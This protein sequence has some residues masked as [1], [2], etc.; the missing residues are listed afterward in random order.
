MAVTEDDNFSNG[1]ARQASRV[2]NVMKN[3]LERKGPLAEVERLLLGKVVRQVHVDVPDDS[4]D[5]GDDLEFDYH[6]P[7]SDISCMQDKVDSLE[8]II[9]PGSYLSVRV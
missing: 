3:M 2:G 9:Y 8:S 6:I 4:F 1:L 5:G 7:T